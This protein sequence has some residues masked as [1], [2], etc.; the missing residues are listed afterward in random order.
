MDWQQ[1]E[2]FKK[3]ANVQ[4]ITRAAEELALTQPALSRSIARL[5]EELG[6]PLF[7]RKIRGVA[8]NRYGAFFLEH[9]HRATDEITMAKQM[10]QDM[11]NP[12]HGT[13]SLGF[14][15]TLGASYVPTLMSLFRRH[16]PRIQFQLVQDST[17]RILAQL[18]SG[19]IDLAFCSP[20]EKLEN[21]NAYPI[22]QEEL[23]LIVPRDHWLAAREEI[24]LHIVANEQFVLYKHESGIRE[25]IE[26]LCWQAGFQP[27]ISFEGVSDATIAGLVGAGFGIALIPFIPGLDMSK[28]S[29]LHVREP[30]CRRTIFLAWRA[31]AYL[32]PA[33]NQFK[34]FVEKNASAGI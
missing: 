19:E 30:K 7:D 2:Y 16:F 29:L 6:V 34:S 18:E 8:L 26:R 3:L 11:V 27:S 22:L 14:I 25:V 15:H 24:D 13:V 31:E 1:L 9:V 20:N 23:Y 17:R 10:L 5:E 12:F 21:I 28:I 4:N 32:S 33:A